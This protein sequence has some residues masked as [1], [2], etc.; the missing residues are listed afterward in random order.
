MMANVKTDCKLSSRCP[1]NE[2][3]AIS[4]IFLGTEFFS[5]KSSVAKHST[6]G[7]SDASFGG[8]TRHIT[9]REVQYD[10]GR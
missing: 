9:L 6:L 1:L 5:P 8:K 7:I 4:W 10:L 3:T 2:K